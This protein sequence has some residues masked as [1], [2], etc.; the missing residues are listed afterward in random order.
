[1]K[2]HQREEIPLVGTKK[3]VEMNEHKTAAQEWLSRLRRGDSDLECV[4]VDDINRHAREGSFTLADIGTS[5]EELEKLRV[6]RVL[7]VNRGF[8]ENLRE[9]RTYSGSDSARH[10]SITRAISRGDATLADLGTS[11]EELEE[12]RVK[13]DKLLAISIIEEGR[14]GP[15]F[16]EGT[17]RD[18][19]ETA[20][21]G[22]FTFADIG[23]SEEE[24]KGILEKSKL[25]D[26]TMWYRAHHILD[27]LRT[28]AFQNPGNY[29][30]IE[31]L[32]TTLQELNRGPADIGTSEEELAELR[33]K[34]CR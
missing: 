26:R 16:D 29:R 21:K 28:P 25:V 19:L 30:M 5:E 27:R 22:S 24:L 17:I 18:L 10:K 3:E 6:M 2:Y 34:M 31:E 23:T 15:D 11:E 32:E 9:S 12:L 20:R 4:D 13:A 8:L 7:S 14:R 33:R 1:M